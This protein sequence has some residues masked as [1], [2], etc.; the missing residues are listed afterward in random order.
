VK[1]AR[2]RGIVLL[3]VCVA[4]AIVAAAAFTANREALMGMSAVTARFDGE[5]ARYLAEAG[6]AHAKWAAQKLACG[7]AAYPKVAGTL[8][9]IGN[10]EASTSIGPGAKQVTIVATGISLNGARASLTRAGINRRNPSP[11]PTLEL[12]A[13]DDASIRQDLPN[14]NF[15]GEKTLELGRNTGHALLGFNL[16]SETAG[17]SVVSAKLTLYQSAAIGSGAIGVHGVGADWEEKDVAWSLAK[18]K[19]A[20]ATPGGEFGPGAV[21]STAV[22]AAS[23]FFTWDVTAI[24]DAWLRN[25]GTPYGLAYHGLLLRAAGPLERAVFNSRESGA[26]APTLTLEYLRAC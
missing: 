21:A 22:T 7:T 23:G 6:V 24:A 1:G 20:W 12:E 8:E 5:R 18:K 13:N 2:Q 14:T 26:N 17:G 3:W 10:Y 11:A 16:P 9:G 4:L 19:T 15:G 25:A